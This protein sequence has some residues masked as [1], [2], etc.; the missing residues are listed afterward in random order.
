MRRASL[1]LLILLALAEAFIAGYPVWVLRPFISQPPRSLALAM[2]LRNIGAWATLPGLAVIAVCAVAL[3][4]PRRRD[5]DGGASISRRRRRR[6]TAIAAT[7]GLLL[8]GLA[9]WI[10][11]VDY[12]QWLF[13]PDHDVRAVAIAQAQWPAGAMVLDVNFGGQARAYPIRELGY[14]HVVNDRLGGEPIVAT[15]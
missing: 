13:H 11:N 1:W 2:A 5:A 12:F 8:G 6:A 3:L 15:Y 9:A 4:R 14:Y 10:A 7:A